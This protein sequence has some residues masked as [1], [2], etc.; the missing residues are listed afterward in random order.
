[1]RKLFDPFQFQ[2][3]KGEWIEIKRQKEE[4]KETQRW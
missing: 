3:E 2:L 1:M 4:K